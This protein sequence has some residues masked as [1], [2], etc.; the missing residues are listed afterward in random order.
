MEGELAGKL[1][2]REVNMRRAVKM[3]KAGGGKIDS[4]AGKWKKLWGRCNN[5]GK[6]SFIRWEPEKRMCSTKD[7]S[8][9]D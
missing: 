3:R 4:D 6:F 1:E 2:Q 8:A 9:R 5:A 7:G